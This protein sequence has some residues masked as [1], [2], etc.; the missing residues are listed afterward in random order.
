MPAKSTMP[1]KP[2]HS[3]PSAKSAMSKTAYVA[4]AGAA[5]FIGFA[6]WSLGGWATS[7][8]G[9][10]VSVTLFALAFLAFLAAALSAR[11]ARGRTRIAWASL[12]VGLLGW[13]VGDG[14]WNY[15][16]LQGK[17]Q[18]FPIVTAAAYLLLPV[19]ACLAMLLIPTN[20]SRQSRGRTLI[21]G[22]IVAG[23][24]FLISWM[25]IL[26]PM[27]DAMSDGRLQFAILLAYPV[28][29]VVLLTVSAVVLYRATLEQRRVLTLLTVGVA[30]MAV[31]DS[32]YAYVIAKGEFV[33]TNVFELCWAAGLTLVTVA[34]WVARKP[35]TPP[36][37]AIELPSW[38]SIWM[39]YA[40][41]LLAV[42]V[43]ALQPLDVRRSQSV[44]ALAALLV[45]AVLV[46]QFLAVS[47]NRRLLAV[48]AEQAQTDAL[49][50]LGNRA[51]FNQ[52][53]GQVIDQHQRGS[54]SLGLIMLD[55]NGFKLIN[56]T[57]GHQAGDELLCGTAGRIVGAVRAG[58]TVAR[59]GGDEFAVIVQDS[60][61]NAKLIAYRIMRA[62]D[63]PFSISG[64]EVRVR[65]SVGLAVL[66]ADEPEVSGEE[67]LRRADVAMYSAKKSAPHR[68][69]T[70]TDKLEVDS[71][72]D[73]ALSVLRGE[74]A[75]RRSSEAQLLAE[76]RL[77]ID[78]GELVPYYQP[79]YSLAASTI[80]G[81][82]ALVRWPHP[83]RGVLCPRDFLHLVRQRGLMWPMTELVVDKALDDAALWRSESVG[84]PVAVN[85]FAPLL[86]DLSLPEKILSGLTKRSLSPDALAV[87]L[88]EDLLLG[89]LERTREVLV[90]LR[91]NGIRIAIDDFGQAYSTFSYLRDLPVDEL[92]LDYS[93]VAEIGSDPRTAVVAQ[94][95]LAMSHKLGMTTVAEGV[96]DAR[97]AEL[98]REFGCDY[99]QGYFYSP[100][101][102]P[103]AMLAL[104]KSPKP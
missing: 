61:E 13:L 70:F 40:P 47:E 39:P 99:A 81:A 15:Y 3:E 2:A 76:L 17:A 79:K 16:E 62:F 88:T 37:N 95:V 9:V 26:R 45:A 36:E 78:G 64:R 44:S 41:L 69:Q 50:G 73:A 5:I 31:A 42:V 25:T 53:L 80:V 77:A 54:L 46:R 89:D 74:S 58:D 91:R 43:A 28:S 86:A 6:V 49:T 51:L 60:L 97:T 55:L 18:P 96:T 29:D 22:L 34:A 4:A 56:D 59:L 103:D 90:Q 85:L 35:S 32:G 98:L 63:S 33:D 8:R 20:R 30:C 23:S 14:I 83:Q 57:L 1:A 87:E 93:F 19:G 68:L 102:T 100:P 67:L 104:L 94:A 65:P 66:E 11:E 75:A 10:V 7:T 21:D 52:R 72:D 82:E 12:A 84:V 92:K 27:Y 48:V 38:A 101:V 24:F 71:A